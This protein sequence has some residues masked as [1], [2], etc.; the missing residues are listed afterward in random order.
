MLYFDQWPIYNYYMGWPNP[1]IQGEMGLSWIPLGLLPQG[2]G[3][4]I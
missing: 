2:H 4:V 3:E 1:S